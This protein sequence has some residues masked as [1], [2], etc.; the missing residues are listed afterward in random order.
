LTPLTEKE[1][2]IVEEA[3]SKAQVSRVQPSLSVSL[4]VFNTLESPTGIL[5]QFSPQLNI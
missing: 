5:C 1:L 3:I 4:T 2:Q